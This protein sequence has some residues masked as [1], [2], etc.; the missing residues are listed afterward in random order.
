MSLSQPW[1]PIEEIGLIELVGIDEKIDQND[2]CASVALTVPSEAGSG[3]IVSVI[4]VQ[5]EDGSGAIL[6]VQGQLLF[7]DADPDIAS[8]DTALAA[9]E[10]PTLLG[11][12]GFVT[13]DWVTDAAGGA[14]YKPDLHIPFHALSTIYVTFQLLSGTSINSDAAD[15]EQLELN[16][17]IRRES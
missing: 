5:T 16:L 10:W 1:M 3:E 8:G 11:T 14:A 7:F 4:L 15:N 2:Y 6:S 13:A 12:L 9:A 17:W